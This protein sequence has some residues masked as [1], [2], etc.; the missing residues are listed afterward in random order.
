MIF[1]IW[2]NVDLVE[3][4]SSLPYQN[5]TWDHPVKDPHILTPLGD[6]AQETYITRRPDSLIGGY[7]LGST[8]H[9]FTHHHPGPCLLHRRILRTSMESRCTCTNDASRIVTGCLKP[10]PPE[11]LPVLP[12]IPPA[13][14]RRKAATLSLARQSL[15]PGHTLHNYFNRPM[16][17]RRPK[18]R[19]LFVIEAQGLL[20]QTPML[21]LRSTIPG[22]RTG[23]KTSHV[24]T[25]SLPM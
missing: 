15:E 1:T 19:K 23:Q 4:S 14:L 9:N 13:E 11:Y 20:A 16:A 18:S 12:G 24:F 5:I 22:K 2:K 21:R 10:T 17:K 3:P 25:L 8:C 6:P 7:W